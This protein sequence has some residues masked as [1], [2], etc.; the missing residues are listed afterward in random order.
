[1]IVREV[2]PICLYRDRLP[3]EVRVWDFRNGERFLGSVE[4]ELRS[5]GQATWHADWLASTDCRNAGHSS[6]FLSFETDHLAPQWTALG[7]LA[8]T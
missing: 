7:S 4:V 8:T 1:M 6:C 3:V 5:V 2:I